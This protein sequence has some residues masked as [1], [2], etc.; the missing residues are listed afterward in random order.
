[1]REDHFLFQE[2]DHPVLI[3]GG[4]GRDWP[5]ARGVFVNDAKNTLVWVNEEDHTRIIAMEF[6]GNIQNVFARFSRTL[7]KIQSGIQ[8]QG[9]DF[10]HN[11]HVGYILTCPSQL[12][13]GMRASVM[14]RLPLLSCRDDFVDI[15]NMMKLDVRFQG[16][17][18]ADSTFDRACMGEKILLNT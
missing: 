17:G 11:K 13:T 10:Q 16:S 4:M 8:E 12:G 14:I 9:Y 1:M 18:G 15:C 2:P 5:D 6:G 3:S 7:G